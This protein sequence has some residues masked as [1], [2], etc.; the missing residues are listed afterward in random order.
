MEQFEKMRSIGRGAQGS[1][2]LV[3][4]KSDKSLFVIKIVSMHEHGCEEREA[5]MS[6]IKVNKHNQV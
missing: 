5:V 1:V 6:E 3:R 2:I 4:R